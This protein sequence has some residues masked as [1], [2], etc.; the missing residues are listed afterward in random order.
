MKVLITG[1]DP[2]GDQPINPAYEAV[3]KLPATI[4]GAQIIKL[5]IPT[6]DQKGL[7]KVIEQIEIEQPD[8]VINVGQAGGRFNISPEKVAINFNNFRIKDNEG[9]QP[10]NQPISQ[11]GETAYFTTL[12]VN[13]M[14]EEMQKA[15]IPSTVSYTAGTFVC[16]QVMYGVLEYVTKHQLPIRAGFI[17]IP[18][19]MEQA[20]KIGNVA[21][22]SLD[23]LAKGLEIC[24][25]ACVTTTQDV[26]GAFGEID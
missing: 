26:K 15:G 1:F 12:P 10:L 21:S 7:A 5:E 19:M 6:V 16:N 25:E 9:N 17:H 24:I 3:K 11:T 18:Y 2:F 4:A 22:L 14:V 13:K 8:V 20:C 23:T